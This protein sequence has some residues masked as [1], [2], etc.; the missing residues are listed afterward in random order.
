MR[1]VYAALTQI[2]LFVSATFLEAQNYVRESSPQLF[3]YDELV[4]LSLEREMDPQLAEKLRLITTTP[5][6]NNEAY[7]GGARPQPGSAKARTLAARRTLEHRAGP[8]T[9]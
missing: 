9:R 5:F 4:Q 2:A 7:L 3:T 8:R 6:V 1:C